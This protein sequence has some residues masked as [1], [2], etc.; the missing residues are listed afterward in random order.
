M[1]RSPM[2]CSSATNSSRV[3][4]QT[5]PPPPEVSTLSPALKAYSDA[6]KRGSPNDDLE[7]VPYLT[8]PEQKAAFLKVEG[9]PPEAAVLEPALKAYVAAHAGEV[10]TRPS[11]LLPYVKTAEEK[12]AL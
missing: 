12:T 1:R 4:N 10:P 3:E 5:C 11:D 6:N 7:L 8:T 9:L 2:P